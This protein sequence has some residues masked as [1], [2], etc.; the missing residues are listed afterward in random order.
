MPTG[1]RGISVQGTVLQ[2][3]T[4]AVLETIET[5]LRQ[6]VNVKD[7]GAI[8]DGVTDDQ[9]AI[10]AAITAGGKGDVHIPDGTYRLAST[11]TIP[12]YVTLRGSGYTDNSGSTG[13]TVLLKD[14]NGQGVILTGDASG[15]EDIQVNSSVGKTGDGIQIKASRAHLL[16]VAVTAMGRDGIR[17]GDDEAGAETI[18]ANLWR[19]DQVVSM[20]NTRHGLY[21]H[22]SNTTTNATFPQGNADV[23][24][25]LGTLLDLRS[26]GGDGLK[27]RNSIDNRF[28]NVTS[29][30]NTGWGVHFEL[31]AR[32]H[33]I[34][35]LYTETNVTG[36]ILLDSGA[37]TNAV[38]G[39]RY[40]TSL[41]I[42]D[43]GTAN[44]IYRWNGNINRWIPGAQFDIY[45]DAGGGIAKL[46]LWADVNGYNAAAIQGSKSGANG[47]LLELINRNT[48]T[49]GVSRKLAADDAHHLY[50]E[51]AGFATYRVVLA[52]SATIA[53]DP[54]AGNSFSI[55][56][57]N[58]TAF[59]ISTPSPNPYIGQRV[60]YTI[61]NTSG[62]ALGAATWGAMFKMATWAQPANGFSRSIEFIYDG[63]N[64]VEI[65]RATIDVPN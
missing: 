8:G 24:S 30:S 35:G 3:G 17:I 32:S 2:S 62:G 65:A 44:L 59:T 53:T 20:N 25:G 7:Y 40:V 34:S 19:L 56:A 42:T 37:N 4:G 39:M 41:T 50:V 49:G 45:N 36:D 1:G 13:A 43:N 31:D 26:N 16:R 55:T 33:H 46:Q 64:L 12:T 11:L 15:M 28:D 22:H 61:R 10:A 5:K 18:N 58:G 14:F 38:W 29:Q 63:T 48:S 6:I 51:D 52:Y 9:P 47:G 60:L 57:T 27:I 23:N 54:T 21:I